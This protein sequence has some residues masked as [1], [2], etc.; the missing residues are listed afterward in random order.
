MLIETLIL[1]G[2]ESV[3]QILRDHIQRYGDT[4][5]IGRDKLGRLVAFPVVDEGG[6]S[7]RSHIDVPDVRR[8]VDDGAEGTNARTQDDDDACDEADEDNLENA[9]T[10]L[11]F[12]L[13]RTALKGVCQIFNILSAVI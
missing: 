4:V 2:D 3:L 11:A 6:I 9:E 10:D 12:P 1:D 7:G 8:G 5:G 13:L